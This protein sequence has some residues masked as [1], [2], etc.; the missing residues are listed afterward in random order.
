M[1]REEEYLMNQVEQYKMNPARGR[2]VV[3]KG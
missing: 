3:P 1:Q 2:A